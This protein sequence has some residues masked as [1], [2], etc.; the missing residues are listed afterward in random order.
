MDFLE[1][2]SDY[3]E[4]V[5]GSNDVNYIVLPYWFD[6]Q[7]LN[8]FWKTQFTVHKFPEIFK[9]IRFK[10]FMT[11]IYV[12]FLTSSNWFMSNVVFERWNF[13][14]VVLYNVELG[15]IRIHKTA[16]RLVSRAIMTYKSSV[17]NK[18][19]KSSSFFF[20]SSTFVG[21]GFSLVNLGIFISC[22]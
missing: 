6:I 16:Y 12:S 18:F 13:V 3:K 17:I 11:Q 15:L 7:I 22:R 14:W 1:I 19:R 8:P 20:M 9:M 5:T 2:F 10:T 21:P 4:K